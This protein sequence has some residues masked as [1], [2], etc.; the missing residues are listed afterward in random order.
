VAEIFVVGWMAGIG[1]HFNHP[2]LTCCHK[3]TTVLSGN[4]VADFSSSARKEAGFSVTQK[5][6]DF[7]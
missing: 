5:I 3:S 2:T 4:T 1:D 6:T 7:Y